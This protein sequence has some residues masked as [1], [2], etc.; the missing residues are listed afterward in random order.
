MQRVLHKGVALFVFN[1]ENIRF[2]QTKAVSLYRNHKTKQ[3]YVIE[4]Y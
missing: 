3:S 1:P 4:F 2:N